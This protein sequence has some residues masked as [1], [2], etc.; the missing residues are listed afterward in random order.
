MAAIRKNELR[1]MSPKEAEAKIVQLERVLLELEGEGKHEKK[2]PVKK[3]IAKLKT[4]LS[5]SRIAAAAKLAPKTAQPASKP[6]NKPV[7]PIST[8]VR[9]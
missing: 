5:M 1:K 8:G 9:K 7:A 3:G 6:L 2:K 4:L